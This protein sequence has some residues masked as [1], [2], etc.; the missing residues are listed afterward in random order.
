LGVGA[1]TAEHDTSAFAVRARHIVA[2]AGN[3]LALWQH[4][5]VE[6]PVEEGFNEISMALAAD[7]WSRTYLSRIRSTNVGGVVRSRS[8][9][10]VETDIESKFGDYVLN[11]PSGARTVTL[12]TTL[13]DIAARY[14]E[15]TANLIALELE[16]RRP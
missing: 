13:D 12:D 7:A 6:I 16:Y 15:P 10:L 4:E 11:M 8:G 3:L 5:T 9:L 14:G 1:W 2:I